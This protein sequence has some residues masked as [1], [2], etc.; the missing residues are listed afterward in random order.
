M[1]GLRLKPALRLGGHGA[2]RVEP[3]DGD[4]FCVSSLRLL[5]PCRECGAAAW[6]ECR[7]ELGVEVMPHPGRERLAV[8]LDS[9]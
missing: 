1:A 6:C 4:F 7:N 5:P 2:L 8:A 9:F 3:V